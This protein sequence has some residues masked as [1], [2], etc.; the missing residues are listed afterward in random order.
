MAKSKNMISRRVPPG[1]M[2]RSPVVRKSETTSSAPVMEEPVE[3]PVEEPAESY[4]SAVKIVSIPKAYDEGPRSFNW[5]TN[6]TDT[7]EVPSRPT[8]GRDEA[9][10]KQQREVDEQSDDSP[11]M[12]WSDWFSGNCLGSITKPLDTATVTTAST[13]DSSYYTD[14]S[15]EPSMSRINKTLVVALHCDDV[16]DITSASNSSID[17]SQSE[18]RSNDDHPSNALPFD[19]NASKATPALK[20]SRTWGDVAD[21]IPSRVG[22]T[23]SDIGISPQGWREIILTQE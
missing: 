5:V 6:K 18:G 11:I 2:R 16:S 3:G 1:F 8:S 19:A 10:M 13:D 22:F 21:K 15:S 9:K 4:E 20:K 17:S 14:S 23:Y 12:S 7:F